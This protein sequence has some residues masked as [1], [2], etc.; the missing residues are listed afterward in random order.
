MASVNSPIRKILKPILFRIISKSAYKLIQSIA[1][2]RDIKL[3]LVEEKEME[4]LKYFIKEGDDVIDLGANYAYYLERLSKIVGKDG[5]VFG[6][7]PVPFTFEVCEKIVRKLK[8]KNI[9]LF[10]YAAN[11]ENVKLEFRLPKVDFGAISA[12]QS[13]RADRNN[14]IQGKESYYSFEKEEIIICEGKKVDD[15]LFE[16]LRTL[17]FIKIDIEGAEL[18]ALKGMHKTIKK[19]NPVILI[20]IVPFFLEGYN[21]KESEIISYITDELDYEMYFYDQEISK[22]RIVDRDL[23]DSNY[24]LLPNESKDQFRKIIYEK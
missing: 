22:L 12:G 24:I 11:N 2:I 4:I 21:I 8:L 17:S 18:F 16:E 1:K 5:R 7:E 20:E 15:L 13:H 9:K 3:R 10:Q 19:F 6:F 14:K 23:W